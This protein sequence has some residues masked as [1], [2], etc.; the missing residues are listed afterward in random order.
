MNKS[1]TPL[2]AAAIACLCASNLAH[3]T[4]LPSERVSLATPDKAKIA[5]LACNRPLSKKDAMNAIRLLET[6]QIYVDVTCESFARV[7]VY[8]S[9]KVASCDNTTGRWA[10]RSSEAIIVPLVGREVLL[11]YDS[12][13]DVKTVLEVANYVASVRSFNG[14]DVAAHI[15]GS[16]R[17][18][19]GK[20]IPFEGAVSFTFGCEDWDGTITKDCGGE[21]CRLFFTQFAEFIV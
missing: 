6:S 13:I 8:P 11:S 3:G 7:D 21:R 16:C 15:S 12:S 4:L 2:T 17:V 18:G 1:V 20:S 9:L 19:D 10:C 5:L 14:R